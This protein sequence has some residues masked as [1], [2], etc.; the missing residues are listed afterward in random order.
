MIC[1]ICQTL[2]IRKFSH[3]KKHKHTHKLP[4]IT[5]HKYIYLFIVIFVKIKRVTIRQ[6]DMLS[7]IRMTIPFLG[8]TY[9]KQYSRLSIIRP[10]FN[11]FA[12]Q[13]RQCIFKEKNLFSVSITFV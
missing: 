7:C 2:K 1:T 4:P 10:W 5:I 11:R 9:K 8:A 12:A 13:P 6:M 3:P